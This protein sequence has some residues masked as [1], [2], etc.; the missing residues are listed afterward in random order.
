MKKSIPN[1]VVAA[2][3]LLVCGGAFL[4]W[5]GTHQRLG[6][7]G[8][9][10]VAEPISGREDVPGRGTNTFTAGTNSI[11]FPSRVLNYDSEEMPIS[12]MVWDVLPKDTTYG[13]RIYKA[14]DGFHIQNM[15]VLMGKDRT[16]IH[17]P[18]YCLQGLGWAIY[19]QESGSIPIQKPEPYTL[20]IVKYKARVTYKTAEGEERQFAGVLVYWYVADGQLTA[21]HRERMW[22]MARD[23]LTKG[24]LQRWAYVTYFAICAPGQEEATYDR[25]KEFIMAAVPEFQFTDRTMMASRN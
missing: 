18:F 11:G 3:L 24:V 4:F 25:M 16:S 17:Q 8:L 1:V 20:P 6:T 2:A 12:K 9:R 7:P 15:G 5:W 23:L 19:A 10:V 14:E 21:N 22:W 13:Q